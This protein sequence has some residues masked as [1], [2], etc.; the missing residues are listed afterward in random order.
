MG[1]DAGGSSRQGRLSRVESAYHRCL[2]SEFRATGLAFE[3]HS[4]V[5]LVYRDVALPCAYR[6]DFVVEGRVVV[7]VKSVEHL[8]PVHKAQV[9]TYLKLTGY[10]IGL[11]MNFCAPLMKDG[12]RS[13]LRDPA[14]A[15]GWSTIGPVQE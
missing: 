1:W 10:P 14:Q 6:L 15:S 12:I 13:L 11:L 9:I 7:E 3:H 2:A 5:P 8:L 4:P